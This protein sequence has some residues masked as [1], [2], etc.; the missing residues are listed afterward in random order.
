VV[1]VT[2]QVEGDASI[3]FGAPQIRRNRDLLKAVRAAEPGAWIVYKPHPDVVAGLRRG[4][5]APEGD[6]ELWDEWV[7]SGAIETFYGQVDAVHVLTSLAGFEALLRDVEVHTWGIPFYAGWGLTQDELRCPRRQRRLSID[8]LVYGALIAYPRY[9]SRHS[10]LF[11]EPE[12]AIEELLAWRSAPASD[13]GWW[14]RLFRQWGR[15]RERIK[16]YQ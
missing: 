7:E 4:S 9:V 12:E 13:L 10:G 11:I 6:E 14:R 2:G 16:P 8:E 5:A 15:W 3:R 1:L